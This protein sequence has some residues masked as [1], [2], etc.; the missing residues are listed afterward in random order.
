MVAKQLLSLLRLVARTEGLQVPTAFKWPGL[1]DMTETERAALDKSRV[2]AAEVR[3]RV[4]MT[5]AREER[6]LWIR[7]A[8]PEDVLTDEEIPDA[9]Q[10]A[11]GDLEPE[12][13]SEWIDTE[14]GH[15]LEVTGTA[16]GKVYFLDRDDANPERQWKW[17][18]AWFLER[19]RPVAPLD[20]GAL[21]PASPPSAETQAGAGGFR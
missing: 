17:R 16:G 10:E 4:G 15:R 21:P 3:T 9:S 7:G 19:C 1:W 2:D 13:G 18:L 8:D 6:A 5:T 14:D 20:T 11:V 12:A